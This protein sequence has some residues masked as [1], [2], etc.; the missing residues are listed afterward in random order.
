MNTHFDKFHRL[1][2]TEEMYW[3]MSIKH[4]ALLPYLKP[5]AFQFQNGFYIEYNKNHSPIIKRYTMS[6]HG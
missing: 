5:Q 4:L 2:S 1:H 6:L 3:K